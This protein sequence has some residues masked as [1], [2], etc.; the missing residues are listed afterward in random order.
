MASPRDLAIADVASTL[1]DAARGNVVD[2]ESLS[3]IAVELV[4]QIESRYE[5]GSQK[6][7]YGLEV[8]PPIFVPG[9]SMQEAPFTARSIVGQWL[10]IRAMHH[11]NSQGIAGSAP[12]LSSDEQKRVL[13][14]IAADAEH[15]DLL[16]RLFRGEE[17]LDYE[18]WKR[19]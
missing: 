6:L 10:R 19:R 2:D 15:S 5:V 16:V 8:P 4:D 1:L 14:Q 11:K 12:R 7:G 13:E 3:A 18:E 9:T 17:P